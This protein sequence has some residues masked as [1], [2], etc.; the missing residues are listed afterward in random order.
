MAGNS[1]EPLF[2]LGE[3]DRARQIIDRTLELDPPAHHRIHNRLLQAWHLTWTDQ[4]A[5][6]DRGLAEFRPML[7]RV[8]TMPQYLSMIA[9]GESEYGLAIDDAE[10]A[11]QAAKVS[12][13][14]RATQNA[15]AVWWVARAAAAAIA[16]RRRHLTDAPESPGFDPDAA[17]ELVR[18]SVA[19]FNAVAGNAVAEALIEAELA[20]DVDGVGARREGA[21]RGR[22]TG[23]I[24]SV[25][26]AAAGR[27]ARVDRPGRG[28][29]VAA[30][31]CRLGIGARSDPHR[32]SCP[33]AR[34]STRC[35]ARRRRRCPTIARRDPA[36]ADVTRS[37]RSCASSPRAGPT[38]RSVPSCSSARRRRAST[39]RTSSPSSAC[40]AAP[41]RRLSRTDSGR[42]T[43]CADHGP[44]LGTVRP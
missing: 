18:A 11:W 22:G 15:G 33:R 41:R 37:R 14:L 5:A 19:D 13:E 30:V 24:R 2:A 34:S 23:P 44:A 32:S 25:H 17:E 3:W 27:A 1:A 29:G 38:V 12:L 6:A 21:R 39:S 42:A 26:D 36:G 31:G 35:A 7:Q 16:L 20:C 40:R 28:R 10:R 9:F 4:L 43:A 8:P